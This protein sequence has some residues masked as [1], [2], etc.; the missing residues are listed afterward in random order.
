MHRANTDTHT[1]THM[2]GISMPSMNWSG[3]PISLWTGRGTLYLYAGQNNANFY[4]LVRITLILGYQRSENARSAK[5]RGDWQ[6][7]KTRQPFFSGSSSRISMFSQGDCCSLLNHG[8]WIVP[9]CS[10]NPGIP[11]EK[12]I[13]GSDP[14]SS[15]Q[16]RSIT[17]KTGLTKIMTD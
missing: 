10:R 16:I 13:Q 8:S 14:S 6:N 1:H 5:T 2:V 15:Q 9:H 12:W 7:V 17:S 4:D 11:Q 3:N